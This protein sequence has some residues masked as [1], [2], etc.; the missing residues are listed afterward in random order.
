MSTFKEDIMQDIG[1]TF[2]DEDEFF[3]KHVVNGKEMLIMTD[4]NENIERT[5]F[6]K[7]YQEGISKSSMNPRRIFIYVRAL[8][9]GSFPR[10]GSKVTIDRATFRVMDATNELGMYGIEL[11]AVNP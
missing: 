8:D 5:K 2:A 7:P 1:D 10:R 4:D 9:F 3:E 11:E 6:T